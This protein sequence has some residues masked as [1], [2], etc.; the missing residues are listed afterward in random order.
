MNHTNYILLKKPSLTTFSGIHPMYIS[1]GGC[2][3]I[4][5]DINSKKK[6]LHMLATHF[7]KWNRSHSMTG[8][9]QCDSHKQ[10]WSSRVHLWDEGLCLWG[11]ETTGAVLGCLEPHWSGTPHLCII[12]SNSRAWCLRV[13][14][15]AKG[16][17]R[18]AWN[19]DSFDHGAVHY[20]PEGQE[21]Q[22]DTKT[23]GEI[24]V[25]KRRFD[26]FKGWGNHRSLDL[27]TYFA[28]W[29]RFIVQMVT[30]SPQSKGHYTVCTGFCSTNTFSSF[31][32]Q[33]ISHFSLILILRHWSLHSPSHRSK[34][35]GWSVAPSC[36]LALL[37]PGAA[38]AKSR[39]VKFPLGD[40]KACIFVCL[41]TDNL[42]QTL[43]HILRDGSR[44]KTEELKSKCLLRNWRN[45][46]FSVW[47]FLSLSVLHKTTL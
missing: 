36:S 18:K 3:P 7:L 14:L 19:H 32:P 11:N 10:V 45:V 16:D 35:Y 23:L 31:L 42:L 43:T 46:S 40:Q 15:E 44:H 33:W 34:S 27:N 25:H 38:L 30:I 47:S 24:K 8:K 20:V 9:R 6:S 17:S 2:T 28:C 1:Q 12:G 41:L 21:G 13:V 29:M 22:R 37:H 26:S 39:A 5:G 4:C